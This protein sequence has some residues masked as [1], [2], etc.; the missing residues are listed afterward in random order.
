VEKQNPA[1][2]ESRSVHS[3]EN[4][5]LQLGSTCT[6]ISGTVLRRGRLTEVGGFSL[7]TLATTGG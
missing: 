5:R 6:S 4:A 2:R 1:E 3:S 7:R